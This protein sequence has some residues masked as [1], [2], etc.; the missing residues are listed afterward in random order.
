MGF[1]KTEDVLSSIVEILKHI[2]NVQQEIVVLSERSVLSFHSFLEENK[3]Q[4]DEQILK[5]FQCH[6]IISQQVGAIN[7][8]VSM[9]EKN[10]TVY[11]HAVKQ[12]QNMLGESIDKLSTR[13][14]KSLET[15]KEKR[16][17]FSGNGIDSNHGSELEFF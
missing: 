17:A 12:D 14:M 11:L 4:P 16:E 13:L 15:A 3:L 1:S 6:D 5:G 9:I 2:D 7:E 10:I 8:A